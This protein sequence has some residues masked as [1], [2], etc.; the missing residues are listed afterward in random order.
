MDET[1]LHDDK[2]HVM[3]RLEIRREKGKHKKGVPYSM[4]FL[5]LRKSAFQERFTF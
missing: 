3:E 1:N 5:A 4:E 2:Q